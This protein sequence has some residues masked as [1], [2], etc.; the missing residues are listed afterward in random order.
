VESTRIHRDSCTIGC[1]IRCNII[2]IMRMLF[3]N[4]LMPTGTF[5]EEHIQQNIKRISVTRR[6]FQ[7]RTKTTSRDLSAKTLF[8]MH[9]DF[10]SLGRLVGLGVVSKILQHS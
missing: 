3:R 4:S 2:T 1:T 10:L 7:S 5:A 9:G 6:A 8:V